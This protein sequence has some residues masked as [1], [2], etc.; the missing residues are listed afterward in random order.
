MVFFRRFLLCEFP[1]VSS[2]WADLELYKKPENSLHDKGKCPNGRIFRYS[3]LN[4]AGDTEILS[5]DSRSMSSTGTMNQGSEIYTS[6]FIR[7]CLFDSF[8][9]TLSSAPSIWTSHACD[10]ISLSENESNESLAAPEIRRILTRVP[11]T[12]CEL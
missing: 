6:T 8:K 4:V 9:V 2:R 3:R 1:A 11:H 10:Q 7:D 5:I 12:R